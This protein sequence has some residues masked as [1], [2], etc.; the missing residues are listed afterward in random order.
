MGGVEMTTLGWDSKLLQPSETSAYESHKS[1]T[2]AE[3]TLLM[4]M[5]MHQGVG[6]SNPQKVFHES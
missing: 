3:K 1:K 5:L 4:I 6:T 2:R